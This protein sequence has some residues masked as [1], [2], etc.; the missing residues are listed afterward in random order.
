MNSAYVPT[1][2]V[3]APR[4]RARSI[5]T[6]HAMATK[7]ADAKAC[8]PKSSA[9]RPRTTSCATNRVR[10][11]MRPL[12]PGRTQASAGEENS[13]IMRTALLASSPTNNPP[14]RGNGKT[15]YPTMTAESALR[16]TSS[17]NCKPSSTPV[18]HNSGCASRLDSVCS[19]LPGSSD[20]GST[21][22]GRANPQ[23]QQL[24]QQP[25]PTPHLGQEPRPAPLTR[26]ATAEYILRSN[27]PVPTDAAREA[28][29]K[30]SSSPDSDMRSRTHSAHGIMPPTL[31]L[32]AAAAVVAGRIFGSAPASRV[33]SVNS[34]LGEARTTAV[35]RAP[36][37]R[38]VRTAGK[39]SASCNSDMSAPAPVVPAAFAAAPPRS[40]GMRPLLPVGPRLASKENSPAAGAPGLRS[41]SASMMQRAA[42]GSR[43]A[44]T[45]AT[46]TP[47]HASL[48]G[49]R[50]AG[51]SPS[52]KGA[53]RQPDA[54]QQT[55]AGSALPPPPPPSTK[56]QQ[57]HTGC[58]PPLSFGSKMRS[59]ATT[60]GV[61]KR[62]VS[63]I[64]RTS[65]ACPSGAQVYPAV[66]L[67]EEDAKRDSAG[68]SSAVPDSVFSCPWLK[69]GV[70]STPTN[71]DGGRESSEAPTMPY[72]GSTGQRPSMSLSPRTDFDAMSVSG[73]VSHGM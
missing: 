72:D 50:A 4:L 22:W 25:S 23:K 52:R 26:A 46:A 67:A 57:T 55:V 44:R 1:A 61:L 51:A 39:R 30:S 62:P 18:K 41:M 64:K 56:F 9:V 49:R 17:R 40:T 20:K 28:L 29:K 7:A 34:R 10:S 66:P 60:A 63:P 68:P 12:A 43:S 53:R 21:H 59:T 36:R 73:R 19:S 2:A 45:A 54:A 38:V 8:V 24:N 70:F 13:T 5:N 15:L 71:R 65:T 35:S 48:S 6:S 31:P 58:P 11:N 27:R 33:S 69:P 32:R 16:K 3:P 14:L 47:R 42:P 37:T